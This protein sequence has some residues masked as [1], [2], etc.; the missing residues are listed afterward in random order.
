[1]DLLIDVVVVV[2][3]VGRILLL[4]YFYIVDYSELVGV[5]D[6]IYA[7]AAASVDCIV[8][9][10]DDAVVVVECVV[11]DVAVEDVALNYYYATVAA[12]VAFADLNYC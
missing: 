2:I 8:V 3:V 10:V 4:L 7:I 12:V 9:V 11:A 6:V 5:N 1:M